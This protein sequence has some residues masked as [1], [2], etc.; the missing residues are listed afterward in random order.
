ML[1]S[2]FCLWYVDCRYLFLAA[3]TCETRTWSYLSTNLYIVY[4]SIPGLYSAVRTTTCT[5]TKGFSLNIVFFCVH[6]DR[7]NTSAAAELAKFR[8]IPTSKKNTIF[9]EHPVP[10]PGYL[11][12][13]LC[14][15]SRSIYGCATRIWS[16]LYLYIYLLSYLYIPGQSPAALT[17]TCATRTWSLSTRR[18]THPQMGRSVLDPNWL[19]ISVD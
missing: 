1:S 8:K 14:I 7:S 19:S 9:N 12:I 10:G 13:Y 15:F 4:L 5:T 3:L 2:I 16:Y 6:N 17:M 11:F 18:R